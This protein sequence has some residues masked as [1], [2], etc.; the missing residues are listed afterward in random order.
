MTDKKTEL[1]NAPNIIG[2]WY[3][4]VKYDGCDCGYTEAVAT[5]DNIL[6]IIQ[7]DVKVVQLIDNKYIITT[8]L[9]GLTLKNT[10]ATLTK[11]LDN[12]FLSYKLK[13]NVGIARLM[14]V[15]EGAFFGSFYNLNEGKKGKISLLRK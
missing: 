4:I 3:I 1:N 15:Q 7:A 8:E 5:I 14:Y 11:E 9:E 12:W 10:E 2:E 6:C 13:N